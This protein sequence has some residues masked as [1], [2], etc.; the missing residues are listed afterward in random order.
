V[1]EQVARRCPSCGA[2]AAAD[3]D[4]CG[5]CLHPLENPAAGRP[6]GADVRAPSTAAVSGPH[7]YMDEPAPAGS[8]GPFSLAPTIPEPPVP[9]AK[10]QPTW[11]CAVC[12]TENPL[13]RDTCAVCGASF[14]KIFEQDEK[15]PHGD[16]KEALVRSLLFP[17]LGQI[18]AGRT[19]DGLARAVLFIWAIGTAAVMLLGSAGKSS[20]L[21][22]LGALF[23]VVAI[24]LYGSSAVDAHRVASGNRP[25]LSTRHLLY[26]TVALIMVSIAALFVLVTRAAQVPR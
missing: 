25:L 12:D 21:V 5:Q 1:M 4:W 7:F 6:A 24:T 13:G 22:P 9:L 15:G 11:P 19:A 16:P 18:H 2:L 14:G 8:R 20:T 17:G 26:G 23:A 3:A 10:R